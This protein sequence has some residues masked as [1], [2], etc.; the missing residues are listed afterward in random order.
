MSILLV[1]LHPKLDF[2]GGHGPPNYF[3]KRYKTYNKEAKYNMSTAN[4]KLLL[5]VLENPLRFNL[6]ACI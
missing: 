6:I 3:S 4:A 2:P 1:E 5:N